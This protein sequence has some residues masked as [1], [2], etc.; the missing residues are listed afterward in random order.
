MAAPVGSGDVRQRLDQA[1]EALSGVINA[2]L[3]LLLALDQD[4]HQAKAASINSNEPFAR[5]FEDG[6]ADGSLTPPGGD[7]RK[8]PSCC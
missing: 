3:P 5:L 8:Q 7:P 2:H 1:L 4:F 6:I